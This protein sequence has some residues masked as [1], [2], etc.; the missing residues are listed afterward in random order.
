MPASSEEIE[1]CIEI[2]AYIQQKKNCKKEGLKPR[3]FS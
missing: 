2:A 1:L 3:T